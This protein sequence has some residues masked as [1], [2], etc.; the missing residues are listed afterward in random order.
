LKEKSSSALFKSLLFP[1]LG[2]YSLE[3]KKTGIFYSSIFLFSLGGLAYSQ[4]L[5]NNSVANYKE[6]VSQNTQL[7][8][9]L[10]NPLLTE[11]KSIEFYSYSLFHQQNAYGESANATQIRNSIAVLPV[12]IYLLQFLHTYWNVKS[13]TGEKKANIKVGFS[14]TR[15]KPVFEATTSSWGGILYVSYEF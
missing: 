4:N 12:A 3:N 8:F 5:V 11:A 15:E 9:T 10:Y 6:T 2:E 14:P 1:G 13:Y 7:A